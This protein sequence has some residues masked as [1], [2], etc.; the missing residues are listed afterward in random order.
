MN[1]TLK[2]YGSIGSEI[3]N[4]YFVVAMCF[5]SQPRWRRLQTTYSFQEGSVVPFYRPEGVWQSNGKQQVRVLLLKIYVRD[6]AIV[7]AAAFRTL[8][9]ILSKPVVLVLDKAFKALSFKALSFKALSHC[10]SR[11]NAPSILFKK[12]SKLNLL[13]KTYLVKLNIS[14]Y[15][16]SI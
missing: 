15:V 11:L 14:I 8:L 12:C 16:N 7:Q 3:M 5:K 10:L 1:D 2:M 13:R 9:D 6:G 4:R